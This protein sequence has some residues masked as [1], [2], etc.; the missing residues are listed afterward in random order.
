[1]RRFFLVGTSWVDLGLKMKAFISER[2]MQFP[3]VLASK[4]QEGGFGYDVV[5][6]REE[7]ATFGGSADRFLEGLQKKGVLSA[8]SSAS[9]L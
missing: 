4:D 7:L 9:S 6:D 2:K 3:M 1:M 5:M 8:S